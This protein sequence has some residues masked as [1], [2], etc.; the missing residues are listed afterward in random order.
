LA[1]STI[2]IYGFKKRARFGGQD[3]VEEES[4]FFNEIG[5]NPKEFYLNFRAVSN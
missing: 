4:D 5:Q 1:K 3:G 2:Y